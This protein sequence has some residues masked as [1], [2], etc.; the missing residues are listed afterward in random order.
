LASAVFGLVDIT[1]T[2][3]TPS[4]PPLTGSV[5]STLALVP[6]SQKRRQR[7]PASLKPSDLIPG[8]HRVR[9]PLARGR[10]A[11]YWY[12]FRGGACILKANANSDVLLAIEVARQVP[13]ALVRYR[14]M[15][16]SNDDHLLY[17]LITKYLAS[18]DFKSLAPRTRK[19]R[20]KFLDKAR[21]E[22]GQM[23]LKALRADGARHVLLKWRDRYRET[24][25]TADELLGA[26]S[27]VLQ[28]GHDT[29]G[30]APNPLRGF[31]RLYKSN[32][33]EVVWE[34]HHLEIL[35]PHCAPEL[36]QAIRLG[37]LTGLRLGDLISLTWGA[38]GGSVIRRPTNK[39]SGRTT[40]S[41][42]ITD[43]LREL[44]A[45][46][47]RC[48]ST[49]ILNSARR[50]PW[51][52]SGLESALRRAKLDA[53]AAAVKREGPNA[54]AGVRH[55][56]FHDLRGTAAT[57]FIRAGLSVEEV[58]LILAWGRAKVERIVI[59][60][61]TGEAIAQGMVERLRQNKAS[62]ESVNQGVNQPGSGTAASG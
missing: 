19:D 9:K 60:Y 37:I 18:P 28:W 20:Q 55:L 42:P 33:A 53:Q 13:A 44:L 50:R 49:T 58:G 62:T 41:I 25:K 43:D 29:L 61:V 17:G 57:N 31:K 15:Q 5:A 7:L 56:R 1:F 46:I 54:D 32:R 23:E 47:P 48:D 39:S 38:V 34:P 8:V 11:E 14:D 22:L 10:V 16:H 40:T 35:L 4:T 59:R 12:A 24:P 45:T 21:L 27:T 2:I 6:P 26:L 52:E 30:Y 51:T 36:E 3:E